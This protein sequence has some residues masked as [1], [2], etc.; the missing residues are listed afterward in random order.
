MENIK[1]LLDLSL[2]LTLIDNLRTFGPTAML[3]GAAACLSCVLALISL[4]GAAILPGLVFGI[5]PVTFVVGGLVLAVG[6]FA[7]ARRSTKATE[8]VGEAC[9]VPPR[10]EY[11]RFEPRTVILSV[12]ASG[13]VIGALALVAKTVVEYATPLSYTIHWTTTVPLLAAGTAFLV[14]GWLNERGGDSP[15]R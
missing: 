9:P 5:G 7:L 15:P 4:V 3:F 6:A 10:N 14:N 13:L 2:S 12:I 11:L 8:V 1:A